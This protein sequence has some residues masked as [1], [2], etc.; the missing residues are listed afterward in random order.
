MPFAAFE[1]LRIDAQQADRLAS[2]I[3]VIALIILAIKEIPGVLD[4]LKWAFAN[5]G[6]MAEELDYIPMPDPVVKLIEKT[7]SADIKS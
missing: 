7:W 4:F 6:K 3:L 2:P 1:R 5:G